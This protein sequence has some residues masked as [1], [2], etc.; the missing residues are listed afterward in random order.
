MEVE[1][2]EFIRLSMM[3]THIDLKLDLY[4][5]TINKLQS[6]NELYTERDFPELIEI[7]NKWIAKYQ[8]RIELL[9]EIKK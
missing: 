7:N 3:D 1:A 4:N 8:E 2:K 6:E 5:A 9:N